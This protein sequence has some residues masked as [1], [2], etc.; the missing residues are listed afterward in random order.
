[1][2]NGL[3]LSIIAMACL[4]VSLLGSLDVT[5]DGQ[6]VSS[7]EY[8]KVR[9]LLA[10]LVVESES[11]HRREAL[12]G[13]L[14]P[15]HSQ[16]AALN[17]L[18][19]ALTKL[20][21]GIGDQNA[22]LPYLFITNEAIQFNR[23]SDHKSDLARFT[24][25]LGT[26]KTHHH[27]R[28]E[29]C[30]SCS[31]RLRQAVDLYQDEFLHGFTL[32]DSD[33]FE[34]W[35]R[36]KREKF[37]QLAVE[38][39]RQLASIYEWRGEPE[40]ALT[41]A[42]RLL[43]IDP[44]HEQAHQQV[45][46][47]LSSN[48]MRAEACIHYEKFHRL[49]EREL[50]VEP[51]EETTRLYEQIKYGTFQA[52][53]AN[54][55]Q[56]M[57][58]LPKN[59]TSF[60]GRERELH[61]INNLLEDPACRLLTL[62]GPGGVGKTRLAV[63]VARQLLETF[64]NGA[65]FVSLAAIDSI[66]YIVP[67]M[68][69]ALGLTPNNQV[70]LKIQ[71]MNHLQD[72][73]LIL[74]LDNFEHLVEGAGLVPEILQRAPGVMALVTSRQRLNL[75]S[76]W[77]FE[78]NGLAYPSSKAVYE[79]Q[80]YDAV[81]LFTQRLHQVKTEMTLF[82]DDLSSVGRI[83]R[84][85]EGLPLGIELAASAMRQRT[86]DQVAEAIENGIEDLSSEWRDVPERH[87]SIT[88]V[89]EHS[90]RLLTEEERKVFCGLAVFRGGFTTEAAS[91]VAEA[92]PQVISNL[93]EQ[94]LLRYNPQMERYTMHELIRQYAQERLRSQG[95]EPAIQQRYYFYF[96]NL[97]EHADNYWMESYDFELFRA[98]F[99]EI[100]NYRN[101]LDA[102]FTNRQMLQALQLA[103]A[104]GLFWTQT[105]RV[106]EGYLWLAKILNSGE[107][108][109]RDRLLARGFMWAGWLCQKTSTRVKLSEQAL[110]I[111][112]ELGDQP[113]VANTLS[114][115]G[116]AK[117]YLG[118]YEES[119]KLLE[120]CIQIYRDLRRQTF[121]A[122]ELI[123]LC[124]TYLDGYLQDNVD[125]VRR[126][127]EQSQNIS[128]Q[129][130][131]NPLIAWANNDLGYLEMNEGNF[132][133]ARSLY[134]EVLGNTKDFFL[135]MD[136]YNSL[137]L[138]CFYLEDYAAANSYYEK[139]LKTSENTEYG[140]YLPTLCRLSYLFC[141]QREY[142]KA[143]FYLKE[144]FNQMDVRLLDDKDNN[145]SIILLN[146]GLEHLS[147]VLSVCG[148]LEW[149]TRLFA[150]SES[151][152]EKF[153]SSFPLYIRQDYERDLAMTRSQLG[154]IAFAAAWAVGRSMTFEEVKKCALEAKVRVN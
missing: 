6:P 14:W 7:F 60:V 91:Q 31:E 93:V 87:R 85:V 139:G 15:D 63:E 96:T 29:S 9:A 54:Q 47:L 129:L 42:R 65:C 141:H 61:E 51:A 5:L 34:E 117:K 83:C 24:H 26:C 38:A 19:N 41:Y 152:R 98:L 57:N 3:Q 56:R 119:K 97:A 114:N 125:H 17:S 36:I 80:A 101:I 23:A 40:Q 107:T 30:K 43:E 25:L 79:L 133:R 148:E 39:T 52:A 22:D 100:E 20:R 106:K 4:S 10:Y 8:N 102:C 132:N 69:E 135:I 124:E 95:M 143:L 149:A 74:V 53:L 18:R 110:S 137:G 75:Q 35:L 13:M 1:M 104:L 68:I 136:T 150:F 118:N 82:T 49:L 21:K 115:L 16:K 12:A 112:R 126:L 134:E 44:Y 73:E 55:K 45:M 77:L 72:K 59:L 121:I 151:Q 11:P 50:G 88:A 66:D 128:R 127:L 71:L 67:T 123:I 145:L 76:E 81:Q 144:V 84:L 99:V 27:R 86:I 138:V 92:T 146:G 103:G 2:Q 48:N 33:L 111:W 70:D 62:V 90:W 120:E 109:P 131:I 140:Y 78:V 108:L 130:R 116:R 147:G 113:G 32:S 58:N 105:G 64:P 122:R 37:C 94:S 89:F 153:A 142:D 46:K 28:L 154:E